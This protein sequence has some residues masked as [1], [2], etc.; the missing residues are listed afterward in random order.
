M[1]GQP[2]QE[3]TTSPHTPPMRTEDSILTACIFRPDDD[4]QEWL[5]VITKASSKESRASTEIHLVNILPGHSPAETGR[6]NALVV[7]SDIEGEW[8]RCC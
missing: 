1:A 5:G 8:R 7:I 6:E 4:S 3:A 2:E